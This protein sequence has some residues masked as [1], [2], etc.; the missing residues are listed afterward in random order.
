MELNINGTLWV[1]DSPVVMGIL[2]VTPDSFFSQSRCTDDTSILRR[3]EEIVSQGGEIIDIGG[4]S[5]RPNCGEVDEMEEMVRVA[6]AV[7]LVR[8][9]FPD[10]PISIDTFRSNVAKA[11][12]GDFGANIVN[13]I[14]GGDIDPKM[15]ETVAALNVPY[16]LMHM[17]GTPQTM[18][19]NL[20]YKDFKSE[21]FSYFARRID[22]LRLMGVK[23]II[24]DPGF[25]FSKTMEQNYALMDDLELFSLFKMPI[26]VGVSRKRMVWQ[27]LGK[28]PGESLNGTTVLNT[29]ALMKGANILRVHD[30]REA[31]EAVRICEKIKS[32]S[33]KTGGNTMP[34][35]N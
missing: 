31:V 10:I 14:S 25:G 6:T 30:V 17:R 27:L 20:E 33:A 29:A 5:T 22:M 9:E 4:Y 19:E 18:G 15:F 12:V 23:D 3:A 2:N 21:V 28:T 26:L 7:K 1:S 32:H 8:R 35:T 11:A 24:I 16:V 13:D 34:T